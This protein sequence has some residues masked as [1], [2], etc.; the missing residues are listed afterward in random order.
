MHLVATCVPRCRRR[1]PSRRRH[2]SAVVAVSQR[3]VNAHAPR[4]LKNCGPPLAVARSRAARRLC[5]TT[6]VDVHGWAPTGPTRQRGR[7]QY[8][9]EKK[10]VSRVH[11][12]PCLGEAFGDKGGTERQVRVAAVLL[13]GTGEATRPGG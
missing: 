8:V 3:A 2:G 1:C 12:R 10:K 9:L 7:R 11:T 4:A 5:A 13:E 6:P